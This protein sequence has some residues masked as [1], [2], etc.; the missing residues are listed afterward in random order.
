VNITNQKQPLF[1]TKISIKPQAAPK[2]T[3]N[4][5][6]HDQSYQ[7]LFYYKF[8][9][10][11]FSFF[12]ES[13]KI[14]GTKCPLE[15]RELHALLLH[16]YAAILTVSITHASNSQSSTSMNGNN[17]NISNLNDNLLRAISPQIVDYLFK[18]FYEDSD[19][20][21]DSIHKEI[22]TNNDIHQ[23]E[24][25]PSTRQLLFYDKKLIVCRSLP[26][27]V[28][29]LHISLPDKRQVDLAIVLEKY[30]LALEVVKR[31]DIKMELVKSYLSMI[32]ECGDKAALKIVLASERF[33]LCLLDQCREMTEAVCGERFSSKFLHRF[34][35]LS[36]GL[37]KILL[38]GSDT[39]KV[40]ELET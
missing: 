28:N 32:N 26:R 20:A 21:G 11:F 9:A 35:L 15:D 3:S 33:F 6:D 1:S 8:D 4:G 31:A 30:L 18:L 40:R 29:I 7:R 14:F 12:F 27:L 24:M 16:T 34:L 19:N 2:T 37:I 25:S 5:L 38:D 17:N 36:L 13:L 39:V 10:V 23:P 22:L